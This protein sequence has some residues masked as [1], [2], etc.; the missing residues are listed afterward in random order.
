M[1][2]VLRTRVM[3]KLES[4][5]EAQVYAVLDYIDFLESKYAA[6]GEA[7]RA[8]GLQ[9]LAEGIEDRLRKRAFN[10]SNLR[11]AFQV[12]AAADRALSGVTAAGRHLLDEFSGSGKSDGAAG[13]GGNDRTPSP[14]PAPDDDGRD[15]AV[16]EVRGQPVDADGGEDDPRD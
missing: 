13:P 8:G 14:V 15:E 10:P 6:D 5:P 11:E 9:R 12:I 3:R 1:H 2:D 7:K 4:L 16:G